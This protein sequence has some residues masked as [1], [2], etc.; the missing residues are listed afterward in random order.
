MNRLA[1]YSR[2]HRACTTFIFAVFAG[3]LGAWA[4]SGPDRQSV[5]G[6]LD[7][8]ARAV[9]AGDSRALFPAIDQRG[10]FAM[11]AI[12]KSRQRAARAIRADYPAGER[13]AALAPIAD[14]AGAADPEAL[15]AQRCAAACRAE[16]GSQLGAPVSQVE[17]DGDVEVQTTRGGRLR[18]HRGDDGAWGI[19]WNTA[20]L[21][22]ERT[23]AAREL[24][25]IEK[26][27]EVYRRRRAL[28]PS[29]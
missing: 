17:R 25:Q 26:N 21:A 11:A 6:A 15:F 23:R 27:A 7:A 24:L 4:C 1:Q 14:A 9:E 16:L 20:A 18:L 19:V 12:V 8:A 13:E 3:I 28:E 10:R 2:L 22:A 29:R 5:R